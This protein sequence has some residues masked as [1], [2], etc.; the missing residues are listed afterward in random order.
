MRVARWKVC[1]VS[2]C[3][4]L[5]TTPKC[6]AHA[7]ERER[8][9]VRDGAYATAGH[10]AFRTLVLHRD[11]ICVLCHVAVATDADHYPKDRKQLV[12]EG[13][14]P[15][16]PKHGRGLCHSCHSKETALHQPGGWNQ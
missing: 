12:L 3:P 13:L 10:R 6:E 1:N 15:N 11:P 2:G 5:T 9:R 8:T 7:I 16:D 4:E 14:D